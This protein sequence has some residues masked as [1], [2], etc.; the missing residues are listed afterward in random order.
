MYLS[1]PLPDGNKLRLEECVQEFVREE[2]LT[3]SDSW[4]AAISDSYFAWEIKEYWILTK[5]KCPRCKVDRDAK[6]SL[7]L[8]KLPPILLIHLKRFKYT[9]MFLYQ[10]PLI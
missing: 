9:G 7:A 6:K 4:Y 10:P 3:G 5:R 8:T 1:I 2:T